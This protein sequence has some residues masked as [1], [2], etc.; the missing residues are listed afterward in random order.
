MPNKEQSALLAHRENY[1]VP[2]GQ[3]QKVVHAKIAKVG[4]GGIFLER[5]RIIHENPKFFDSVVKKNLEAMGY[6]VEILYH[7][8]DKYNATRIEDKEVR[9]EQMEKELNELKSAQ[10]GALAAKDDEIKALKEKLAALEGKS[11]DG[12]PETEGK[13]TEGKSKGDKKGGK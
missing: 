11:A 10:G 5:P 9:F 8:F 3:G 2:K 1:E 6:Q 12:K 13:A 4:K 7:P